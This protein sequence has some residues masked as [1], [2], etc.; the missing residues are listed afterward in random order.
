M[1][2]G[3]DQI[4]SFTIAAQ[5]PLVPVDAQTPL[6]S[7]LSLLGSPQLDV[8]PDGTAVMVYAN[9]V[10]YPQGSYTFWGHVM[11]GQYDPGAASAPYLAAP[12]YDFLF[13]NGVNDVDVAVN[14][15][16]GVIIYRVADAND[17]LAYQLIDA[18]GRPTGP[19]H[20]VGPFGSRPMRVDMN[21]AGVFAIAYGASGQLFGADGQSLGGAFGINQQMVPIV[22]ST[23]VIDNNGNSVFA[24][25]AVFSSG[26][27]DEIH[28]RRFDASGSPLSDE[29][30]V[31][32][33]T[34]GTMRAPEI[35]MAADGSFVVVWNASIG[36]GGAGGVL[37][38]RYNADGT[39]AGSETR[40]S[41]QAFDGFGS[42]SPAAQVAMAADGRFA[43]VWR[44]DDGD[45]KGIYA[46]QFA[47][48]GTPLAAP[49]WVSHGTAG[50][51]T[52]PRIGM[53]DNGD[54]VVR[55]SN[56]DGTD[57]AVWISAIV[58][59][60]PS[61]TNV[62][63][64]TGGFEDSPYTI[65]YADLANAA[66]EAD[67]DGTSLSFRVEGV[68]NGT[69]T[70][71]GVPVT[72]GETLLSA[73]ESLVWTPPADA[74]GTQNA[75]TVRAWDGAL[76]SAS[77][78][79][80]E[81]A[82]TAVNDAPTF[83]MGTEE[84]ILED[85]GPQ[86]V[87]N[88]VT[89]ESPGPADENSQTLS[90][91]VGT[92]NDALFSAL[93]AI[94]ASGTL[95]YTPAADANGSATVTVTLMDDG[96]TDN[97][98]VDT[99]DPQTFTITIDPVNDVPSFTKGSDQTV[100]EDAGA[101]SLTGWA[102]DISKGPAN[103][104]G[105][106]LTFLVSTDNDG[107]FSALAGDR[108][109]RPLTYTPAADANGSATVTVKLKDDGGTANGGVDTSDPQTF[110][111]TVTAVNDVP[112][113]TKGSDQT[114]L[115]DTGPQSVTDWATDISK[116][117]ADESSQTLTFLVSTD[118]DGLFSALPAIDASGTLTYTPAPDANGSATVTV[119]LKDD[120]GTAN[121][122][123]DT[124][125]AQTFTITVTAVNDVPS[126]TKG[127]DQTVL[128]DAGPQSV[129]GWAT[130]ISKGPANESGQTLHVPGEH[131]QRLSVQSAAGD[132]CGRN[133]DLHASGGR[134][135]HRHGDGE[136]QRQRR[137]GQWWS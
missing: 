73:G 122:G 121:G 134:Q 86:S 26:S 130:D 74:N 71:D 133:A 75:F 106:T 43:I 45:G 92:D 109:E 96:G 70:K 136:A 1:N 89:N 39:P 125:A 105:Q 69:L 6:P 38:Q 116:G 61:L 79:Q 81:V 15:T 103:E 53:A 82:V 9:N 57:D 51:Q 131:R 65:N 113:F 77:A 60:A 44:Q 72:P 91:Q 124:S 88:W 50:E 137:H 63:G 111:I 48:D 12:I 68:T 16:G 97:G 20:V 28:A 35:A 22:K 101:Q 84:D 80:I 58:N 14:A 40:V 11:I 64:L 3:G 27:A 107:L 135:R 31:N 102:T 4:D 83:T 67:P 10:E 17:D 32:T 8:R 5:S 115:E 37:F 126:F 78:V 118:N 112:S 7:P 99:S 23:V 25:E 76:A 62:N 46:Q 29:F 95:T 47:A 127:S 2:G 42:N 66:D 123:V 94:D 41:S 49:T 52:E 98:G 56:P 104:S 33:T 129:T 100:D 59:G 36:P 132:R 119:K 87:S 110:T 108:R 18:N 85:A 117:P 54:F 21:A 114:V 30:R 19:I 24:W 55:W 93:P 13:A 120:G 128:E 34:T 90:I